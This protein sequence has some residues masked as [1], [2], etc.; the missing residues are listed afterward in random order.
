MRLGKAI[1]NKGIGPLYLSCYNWHH[2]TKDGR[3]NYQISL[4]LSRCFDNPCPRLKAPALSPCRIILI[5][6]GGE[7]GG[8]S[9]AD[10]TNDYDPSSPIINNL[11][12]IAIT[13]APPPPLS[14][15][16]SLSP[17]RYCGFYMKGC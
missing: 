16:L 10:I 14:Q 3:I 13:R 1:R 4:S 8:Q 12:K 5:P 7:G 9:A 6:R 2:V 15:P 17:L 11:M